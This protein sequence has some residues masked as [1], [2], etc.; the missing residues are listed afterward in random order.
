MP[1]IS[2]LSII[3]IT[4]DDPA[5]LAKTLASAAPLR[6][7]GVEHFVIDGNTVPGTGVV[8]DRGDPRLEVYLR[9]PQG[10]ADAFNFGLARARGEWVWFLNGGDQIDVRLTAE[11]L[12]A[13]L[14]NTRA[15]VVIGGITYEGET[16]PR[17]HPS[18]ELQ[19]PPFRTW[20]PHPSTLVRRRLFEQLGAFDERY[21]VAMDYEWWLRAFSA[22]VRMDVLAVP[23]T[24][25]APDGISQ[26]SDQWVKIAR[27]RDDAIRRH[28]GRLWRTWFAAGGR[29][30]K[31][32]LTARFARRLE[33]NS[34]L[35]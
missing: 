11:F 31:A 13:L 27:E 5:G 33:P 14:D 3:T 6:S 29:L 34:R 28:E 32:W 2:R 1:P 26:Q 24:V 12:F 23:F 7:A 19:W 30:L 21:S 35:N 16:K 18:G 15:D 20:I 17:A 22:A 25:F 8:T 4:K 10:I 9:P